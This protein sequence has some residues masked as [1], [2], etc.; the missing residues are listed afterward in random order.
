MDWGGPP[1]GNLERL[2]ATYDVIRSHP[3]PAA[4]DQGPADEAAAGPKDEPPWWSPEL[5]DG[6]N[7]GPSYTDYVGDAAQAIAHVPDPPQH[8]PA[9]APAVPE[10]GSHLGML[11]GQVGAAV[12]GGAALA[13]FARHAAP[14]VADGL[15]TGHGLAEVAEAAPWITEL[16]VQQMARGAVAELSGAA[17]GARMGEAYGPYG[18][19]AGATLGAAMVGSQAGQQAGDY[20]QAYSL[21]DSMLPQALRVNR[22]DPPR[23]HGARPWGGGGIFGRGPW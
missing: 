19:L 4:R 15:A 12:G 20:M 2:F 8:A 21:P 14:M 1:G 13:G 6:V 11:G 5:E 17:A 10:D 3:V 16:G 22:R 9:E 18:A 7:N 23:G